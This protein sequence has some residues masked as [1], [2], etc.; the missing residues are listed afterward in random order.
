MKVM[1]INGSPHALGCTYT[2]LSEIAAELEKQGI[3]SEIIHIGRETIVGCMACGY[4]RTHDGC[5]Y[6]DVVNKLANRLAEADGLIFGSPVYYAG[7]SGQL[8]C[9]MDRLFYSQGRKIAYKPAAA[10]V[11]SRRAG[12]LPAFDEIN[13]YFMINRMPVITSQ[14]WNQ[15]YGH[16]ADDVRRD[17]E[18][19]QT[20]R[21]LARNMAWLLKCIEAGKQAGIDLPER[22]KVVR[23][24]FIR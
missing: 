14:Y 20:M 19:L 12:C 22:E 13:K 24:N 7:L 15:V 2:A 4:C 1:M 17:D 3:E 8:K 23:T 5:A 10:V 9:F 11:S 18:G 16:S 21:T 6:D